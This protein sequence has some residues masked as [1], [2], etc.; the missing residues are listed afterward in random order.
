[1]VTL[2]RMPSTNPITAPT[3]IAA[4]VLIALSV[5]IPQVLGVRI[6]DRIVRREGV[7]ETSSWGTQLGPSPAVVSTRSDYPSSLCESAHSYLILG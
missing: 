1:M 7:R 4:P 3:P 2:M 5:S 6:Y